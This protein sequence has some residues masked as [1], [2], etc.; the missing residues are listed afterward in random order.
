MVNSFKSDESFLRKLAIGAA[1]TNATIQQLRSMGFNPIELERGS[2]GF[3]IWKRIKIK[4]NRVPDV[5]CL[6]SG[7]RF[8]SRGKTKLE[9]SM[10][11]SL[12]A[13]RR[14]WNAGMCDDDTVSIVAFKQDDDVPIN[15]KQISPVH[16]VGVKDMR[17]AFAQRQVSITRPKGAEE[18]SEI[19]VTWACAVAKHQSTVAAV[20]SDMIKLV[21][22]ESGAP[23]QSIRLRRRGNDAVPT[24]LPQVRAGDTVGANQ[25]VAAV[26]PVKT[27]LE[28]P[29]PVNED[30]FL[31][32]LTSPNLSER[33]AAAKAMR[34]RGYKRKAKQ[35]LQSRM[36]DEAED[37]YV[38][39]EAAAALAAHSKV[40]G[41]DF[42]ED[43]L[44]HPAMMVPLETQL[45]T[46][47]VASEIDDPRSER[48]LTGVLRDS[49]RDRELRAG[50]AWA[51]GQFPSPEAAAALVDVFDASPWEVKAEA[52]RALLRIAEPQI[53]VLVGLLKGDAP[54][55]RDGISWVLARTG[56]FRPA[57]AIVGADEN[58]R[59]WMSYIVGYGQDKFAQ[60]DIEAICHTDPEVYFAASVL[61]QIVKSWINGLGEY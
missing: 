43:K 56:R 27:S 51:L 22:L 5:L 46:V 42:I 21:P 23:G 2:T 14:A 28:C 41:W 17:N 53:S 38:Q 35:A 30:Y 26:V 25:I 9:I 36:T 61:H 57:D 34:Y 49:A 13:P 39:L 4:R 48:L 15:L 40:S 55:K 6:N 32:K 37:I 16:F 33:Y 3:K 24:L 60:E 19:R 12:S 20:E 7:L 18:G 59:K 1:A 54:A 45:E 47:I 31:R 29:P 11:H 8:E 50:A 10:S 44:K 52:A 58:L